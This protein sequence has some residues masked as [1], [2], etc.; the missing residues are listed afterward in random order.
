[1]NFI[2][3]ITRPAG[4]PKVIATGPSSL[5]ASDRL[6][7]AL[8][9]LSFGLGL[10]ELLA[11]RRLTRALGMEGR[12][13]LV[14]LY[15]AREIGAGM[16]TL[17]LDKEIGL[18]SRMA[19]DA[20]DLATLAP[21][22]RRDNPKRRNAEIALVMVFGVALLDV[23]GARAVPVRHNRRNKSLPNYSDRS[24]FP[25]GLDKARTAAW[26]KGEHIVSR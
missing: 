8:G 2:S 14:R 3:N 19:G 20:L 16:L 5:G 26:D 18:L 10:V 7:R 6:A 22:L 1:V 23:V 12:E 21:A 15:G 25:Q 13:N 24:G 11:P 17:S 9:W 4:D